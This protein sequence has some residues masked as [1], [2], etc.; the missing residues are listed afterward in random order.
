MFAVVMVKR[1]TVV[2]MKLI[3]RECDSNKKGYCYLL[4]RRIYKRCRYSK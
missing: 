2:W 4:V 1:V 3:E